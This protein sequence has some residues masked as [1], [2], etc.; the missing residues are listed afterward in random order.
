VARSAFERVIRLQLDKYSPEEAQRRHVEI[1][2]RGLA[3]FLA[4][5][6]TR[7]DVS[8]EVDGRRAT[9]EDQVKPFGIIVYRF[10]RMREITVY[11]LSEARRLSPVLSGRYR[12]SWFALVDG[13]EIPVD[14]ISTS[15]MVTIT[16]DQPYARKIHVG[17]RGFEKH[18]GIVE[19]VR[20]AVIRKYGNIVETELVFITLQGGWVLRKGLRKIH[21]G[22][23]YGGIRND[24]KKGDEITYPSLEI[25]PKFPGR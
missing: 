2:R 25:R 10:T 8:I 3:Q 4:T 15:D 5:Q 16:D 6:S 9:S 21:E 13:S 11:A 14:Q 18:K 19:K 7:P 23:R 24:A 17:A 12:D 22:R 20:Q 1:A